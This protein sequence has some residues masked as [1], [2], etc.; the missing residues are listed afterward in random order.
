M[1]KVLFLSPMVPSQ[2]MK[3]TADF[4]SYALDFELALDTPEH[5]I[6]SRNNLTLH[7]IPAGETAG[8]TAFYLQV[9]DLDDFWDT[10]KG[11]MDEAKVDGLFH[12]STGMKELVIHVPHTHALL[13]V[14]QAIRY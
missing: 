8:E 14:G 7:I 4:F 1:Y 6:M 3:A 5:I 2:Q 10:V 13:H 9:D 12:R 11:K